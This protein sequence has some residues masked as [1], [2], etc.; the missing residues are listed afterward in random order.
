MTS[1]GRGEGGSV[2][3]DLISEGPLTKHLMRGEGGQKRT[4]SS[5][6]IYRR[7]VSWDTLIKSWGSKSTNE[8]S[9]QEH[10]LESKSENLL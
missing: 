6:V 2:K 1:D 3:S 4:K 9:K 10:T 7:P 5:D 8:V